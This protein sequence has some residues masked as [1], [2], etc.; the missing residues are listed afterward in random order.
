MAATSR[1]LLAP[2]KYSEISFAPTYGIAPATCGELVQGYLHGRDFLVN[3]PIPL[4]AKVKVEI[5][6]NSGITLTNEGVYAKMTQTLTLFL[7]KFALEDFGIKVTV[8]SDIPRGKGL[9]SSTSELTAALL[10]AA[11]FFSIP[12]SD[13]VLPHMEVAG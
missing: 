5:N 12:L 7:R 9:A 10:A 3:S 11:N 1:L 8:L 4:F 13:L 2:I 6:A